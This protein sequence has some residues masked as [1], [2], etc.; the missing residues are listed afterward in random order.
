MDLYTHL[1]YILLHA[2]T[3]VAQRLQILWTRAL[4]TTAKYASW[5]KITDSEAAILFAFYLKLFNHCSLLR[6][7]RQ[8]S[9]F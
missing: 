2:L 5:V 3:T 9:V 1:K 4:M 7:E 6:K 8:L